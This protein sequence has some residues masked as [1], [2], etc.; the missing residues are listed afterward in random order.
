MLKTHNSIIHITMYKYCA[1][2]DDEKCL[3]HRQENSDCIFELRHEK[4]CIPGFRLGQT[5]LTVQPQKMAG[6]LKFRI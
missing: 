2:K 6:G 5:N 4:T 3:G 1:L